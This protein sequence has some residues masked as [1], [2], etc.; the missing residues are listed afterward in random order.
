MIIRVWTPSLGAPG[1][2]C[3]RPRGE[4]YWTE[5]LLGIQARTSCFVSPSARVWPYRLLLSIANNI[6]VLAIIRRIKIF[7]LNEP[8]AAQAH[9]LDEAAQG[10]PKPACELQGMKLSDRHPGCA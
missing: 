1:A 3:F 9:R 10:V 8:L 7:V 2:S 5:I 6:Q 4:G